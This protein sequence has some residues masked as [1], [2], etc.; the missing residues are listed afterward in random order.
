[1]K[2]TAILKKPKQNEK[3]TEKYP[4][5]LYIETEKMEIIFDLES[6]FFKKTAF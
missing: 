3:L 6:D 5:S 1:M 4:M 2:I